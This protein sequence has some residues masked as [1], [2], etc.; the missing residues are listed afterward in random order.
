MSTPE[1]LFKAA[2]QKDT[3]PFDYIVVGSGAGGGPLACRLA[4]AGKRVLVVEAGGDPVKAQPSPAWPG[5]GNGEVTLVPGYHA[6]AT[7][8]AEMSWA[9][10]VR[11][12]ADTEG[13]ERDAKYNQTP[14]DPNRPPGAFTAIDPKYLDPHPGG[15]RQG[16]FYPRS[17]G[18]G[19]CTGHHAM[20]MI[21]PNDKD[22]NYIADLTGDDSWMAERMRPF[23]AKIERCLYI[24]AYNQFF[25]KTLGLIYKLWRWL[26]FLF[27]PGDM[28]DNGGHGFD[29]WQ[30]TS[31]IDPYL[32]T[33]IAE[34]DRSLIDAIVRAALAVFH[35]N[36]S[37][38]ARLKHALLRLRVV[39]Q[40]DFN[41]INTR[42][43]SPEGLFLIPIG[44]ESQDSVIDE[45]QVFLGCR[46]GVREFLLKTA[47]E[48]PEKLVIKTG[49]HV[50][51]V[52][53]ERTAAGEPPRA[54]GVEGVVGDHLYE[55][56]PLQQPVPANAEVRLFTRGEVVLCG[57]SFN[58][59][60]LLMLSG[61][62]DGSHL[63]E[64]GIQFL[65]GADG[66]PMSE[67][68][69]DEKGDALPHA[70][71]INLP[72]VGSNLQ[73]RY[74][75]TVVSELS[76]DLSTLADLSFR[77]G[78]SKDP[79]RT[80]WLEGKKGLYATN[81]GILAIL[82]RS[83]ALRDDE[84]ESDLFTFA[85]PATFRGY[86]WN[87]SREIF[88][89]TL[90]G[91]GPDHHN[92]WS[93]VILKAYTHNNGGTVRLRSADSFAMPE[94]CF[95]SFEETPGNGWKKDLA[96]VVDAVRY[97]RR[98][99]ASNPEQFVSEIQP[100]AEIAD[101][102]PEMEE[103]IKT[104]T[105]GHHACGTCRIGSDPWQPDSKRL[106][107]VGAVVDSHFRIH[108]VKGLRVVDASV[109]PKI[110]G[111]FILTSIFMISEKA[112][113]TMLQDSTEKDVS[114]QP[115]SADSNLDRPEVP[116]AGKHGE[117]FEAVTSS[118]PDVGD[119]PRLPVFP[120][121][122]SIVPTPVSKEPPEYHEG[123]NT[124]KPSES[125]TSSQAG[126]DAELM[127]SNYP[128]G[129][130]VPSSGSTPDQMEG[131]DMAI[132]RGSIPSG[133]KKHAHV[134]FQGSTKFYDTPSTD[135]YTPSYLEAKPL[136]DN[137]GTRWAD[138]R[139]PPW[140]KEGDHKPPWEQF[141]E[142][143]NGIWHSGDPS[144]WNQEI[145]TNTV[146]ISDPSGITRGAEQSATYFRT[147][148]RFFPDLRGEVVSWSA[149]DRELFINWRFRI[150]NT[151][152]KQPIGPITEF[153]YEHQHGHEFLVPVLDKFC[154]VEGHV[155]Y[156]LAYFDIGT[157]I[158]FLSEE[159]STNELYDYILAYL[160]T[161]VFSG[162]L[163][164]FF[165]GIVNLFLGLFVWPP[166]TKSSGLYASTGNGVVALK[167]PPVKKAIEY[168][169]TRAFFLEGPYD[170]PRRD[171]KRVV[172][173]EKGSEPFR[174]YE[175][176]EVVDGEPYWYLVR[177][178]FDTAKHVPVC[179]SDTDPEVG[180][181]AR[182]RR[183]V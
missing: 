31:F 127:R 181:R 119:T 14:F 46:Q 121:D 152:N 116:Q 40:L 33:T 160:W 81:G 41:D 170:S 2:Q 161:A 143:F 182:A 139:L 141:V 149:N 68:R 89:R 174:S 120:A 155:S 140:I 96:A 72:G 176:R 180:R 59:P 114:R 105:W 22:W 88:R 37:L 13:Q 103:W 162:G 151:K 111:Y 73:D 104:Q 67:G 5:A 42:R 137:V 165:R 183:A 159:Y 107:D 61:I 125:G 118:Y 173:A 117:A 79:G 77:P 131:T 100:G 64:H 19:G 71:V 47:K 98:V 16:I 97:V 15:G 70:P 11:H 138:G 66:K 148:F 7:E 93:W 34:S 50:T 99:N 9:F 35:G 84:P 39:E 54:I 12:Y 156:R 95:H 92:F 48:V 144:E 112:A 44:V 172:V 179:K 49:I 32:I 164:L 136:V 129:R 166:A 23:F 18:L 60:Q 82:R 56:S 102:S 52:L 76:K 25:R 157:F 30:P 10:S 146:I 24:R 4:L 154:F 147:L 85:A 122:S 133:E 175:D 87:W 171:G 177:P 20:I 83:S 178:I 55:A 29:G 101:D 45:G 134:E 74:E 6:S 150:P 26:L 75:V 78:D 1:S 63:A 17:S 62:G 90:G 51:R 86:Y 43:S 27:H 69:F 28:V 168:E 158:G 124:P 130:T 128:A 53:F 8:G 126:T 65:C 163:V 145:F 153:L 94:I 113:V 109:F 57:G 135:P 58:T 123:L 169:V 142:W 108:G 167:W 110:P 80:A 115:V 132:D 91:E 21:V 36:Y 106:N 3:T 38:V